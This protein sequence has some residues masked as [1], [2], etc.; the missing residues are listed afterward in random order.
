MAESLE[1]SDNRPLERAKVFSLLYAVMVVF[2]AI[3]IFS[4]PYFAMD[5]ADARLRAFILM[6]I[7]T[8]MTVIIMLELLRTLYECKSNVFFLFA[9]GL[10]NVFFVAFHLVVFADKIASDLTESTIPLLVVL[11]LVGFA[12]LAILAVW[13]IWSYIRIRKRKNIG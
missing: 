13:I 9:V 8:L 2:D 5:N 7:S 11:L 3:L 6:W 12:G 1:C 10:L 4:S